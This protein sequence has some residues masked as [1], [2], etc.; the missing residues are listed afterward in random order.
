MTPG[1]TMIHPNDWDE[2]PNGESENQELLFHAVRFFGGQRCG[3]HN[4]WLLRDNKNGSHCHLQNGDAFEAGTDL[5]GEWHDAGDYIKFTLNNAWAA[6]T[7]LKAYDTF[8]RAFR[9]VYDPENRMK[10]NGIPDVF[11][12]V[13]FATDYLAKLMPRPGMMI[14]RVGG[15]P[16][17]NHWVTSPYQSMMSA[18]DGGGARP[19]YAEGKADVAGLSADALALMSTLY[20]DH[21]ADAAELHLAK[22]IE[23]YEY[24]QANPDVTKDNFYQDVR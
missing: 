16:V 3:D 6:Y 21:D 10:P 23:M 18:S 24:G 8:P 12:E 9:D 20:V 7:L 13:R 1:K 15:H 11:D 5:R 4:N 2:T 19:V 22:A 14:N 17:H